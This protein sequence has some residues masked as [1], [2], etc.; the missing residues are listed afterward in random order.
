[1]YSVST[2]L[3][4]VDTKY[5]LSRTNCASHKKKNFISCSVGYTCIPIHEVAYV[6]WRLC[7]EHYW[8]AKPQKRA[9]KRARTSGEAT[10]KIKTC[11]SLFPPQSPRDFSAPARQTARLYYLARPPKTAMLRRLSMKLNSVWG[12]GYHY[13]R[14]ESL[15][16]SCKLH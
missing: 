12:R 10:R 15:K 9:R 13:Y 3:S 16:F 7:R 8:A 6:A 2:A 11:F 1:M 4:S 14:G 5:K